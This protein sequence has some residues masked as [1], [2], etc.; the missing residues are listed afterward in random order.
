MPGKKKNRS[1]GQ[2]IEKPCE[3]SRGRS[4]GPFFVKLSKDQIWVM[5]GQ[6]LGQ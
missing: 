5:L 1:E 6:K 4:F 3:H 2:I